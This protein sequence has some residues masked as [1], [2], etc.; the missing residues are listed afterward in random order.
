MA[1][2][3][4]SVKKRSCRLSQN[5][6]SKPSMDAIHHAEWRLGPQYGVPAIAVRILCL[7]DR[8]IR[9]ETNK[10]VATGRENRT[11]GWKSRARQGGLT[12][13]RE[14]HRHSTP[15]F[16][17]T[18]SDGTSPEGGFCDALLTALLTESMPFRSP[19]SGSRA[20]SS[21]NAPRV[22]WAVGD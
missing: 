19:R 7:L 5:G 9:G 13:F 8:A 22:P 11:G 6:G 20:R 12:T 17:M 4:V 10:V 18:T 3:V 16:D 14:Q 21:W 2:V 1:P 15:T